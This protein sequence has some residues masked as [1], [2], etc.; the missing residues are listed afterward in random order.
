MEERLK[1][2]PL[3]RTDLDLVV[4]D[5]LG[6]PGGY[7]V[8]W[9]DPTTETGLVEPMRTLEAHQRRGIARHVL[10]AGIDR[11]VSAGAKRVKI[12]FGQGNEAA[13]TL[14]LDVGFV[15]VKE[16]IVYEG[17]TGTSVS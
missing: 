6:E 7:G 1:Q 11:L 15:P 14:Y 12:C 2:T 10:T 4:I 9:Y 13:R 17:E 8:F 5:E 3:Y 16:T